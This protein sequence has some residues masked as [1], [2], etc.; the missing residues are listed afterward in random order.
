M[1]YADH[2]MAHY[3]NRRPVLGRLRMCGG[4]QYLQPWHPDPLQDTPR[5]IAAVTTRTETASGSSFLRQGILTRSRPARASSGRPSESPCRGWGRTGH[6]PP[7]AELFAEFRSARRPVPIR[8]KI[9]R[10]N[11]RALL[12]PFTDNVDLTVGDRSTYA[13]KAEAQR[14]K[15]F[16]KVEVTFGYR[17]TVRACIS[18]GISWS[19]RR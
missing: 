18:V 2:D 10:H 1:F 3:A 19:A 8:R 12:T 17:H 4:R 6:R 15:G 5:E 9:R 16:E 13:A 7:A 14:T 11:P